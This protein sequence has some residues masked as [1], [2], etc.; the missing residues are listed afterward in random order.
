MSTVG[1]WLDYRL[2]GN[3]LSNSSP[4][5]VH[6]T[7]YSNYLNWWHLAVGQ[8]CLRCAVSTYKLRSRN[9]R[10]LGR[11]L[12]ARLSYNSR[13]I[14]TSRFSYGNFH[15]A[16]IMKNVQVAA[17]EWITD[18]Q[19]FFHSTVLSIMLRILVVVSLSKVEVRQQRW[20]WRRWGSGD[21]GR[22]L[23]HHLCN[24]DLCCNNWLAEVAALH[25]AL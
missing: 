12:Y 4:V 23:Q 5:T 1:M 10:R 21:A 3:R 17:R 8:S 2:T 25:R 13:D 15:L 14:S 24:S 16:R 11:H 7:R 9:R 6:D 18:I 19:S 20:W 22:R